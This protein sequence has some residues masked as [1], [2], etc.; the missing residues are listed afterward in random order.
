MIA[1]IT[2]VCSSFSLSPKALWWM[3][4]RQGQEEAWKWA[5]IMMFL[6]VCPVVHPTLGLPGLEPLAGAFLTCLPLTWHWSVYWLLP[7][8]GPLMPRWQGWASC[9]EGRASL[10]CSAHLHGNLGA[11]M[12]SPE[13][14][15]LPTQPY[16]W[17]V[18]QEPSGFS[19][20]ILLS[21]NSNFLPFPPLFPLPFPLFPSLLDLFGDAKRR[22]LPLTPVLQIE[23]P[24][25]NLR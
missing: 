11:S 3:R 23:S 21:A 9:Q 8:S 14:P 25:P 12:D 6:R 17:T 19:P 2:F 7:C 20:A 5:S 15:P 24:V 18:L 1:D 16:P 10:L 13:F 22:P 4:G